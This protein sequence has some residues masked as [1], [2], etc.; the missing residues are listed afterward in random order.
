L[1]QLLATPQGQQ[2]QA[3]PVPVPGQV[4][5][6]AISATQEGQEA[7]PNP[8]LVTLDLSN[9]VDITKIPAVTQMQSAFQ[10]QVNEAREAAEAVQL[11]LLQMEQAQA[12]A[13]VK[14]PEQELADLTATFSQK[15]NALPEAQRTAQVRATME[16]EYYREEAA[17]QRRANQA[18]TERYEIEQDVGAWDRFYAPLRNT[19]LVEALNRIEQQALMDAKGNRASRTFLERRQD[20][21]VEKLAMPA[22]MMLLQQAGGGAPSPAAPAAPAAPAVPAAPPVVLPNQ[23]GAPAVSPMSALLNND[24]AALR[25]M[26]LLRD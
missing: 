15:W 23:G 14:T 6:E 21:V 4:A 20:L 22:I 5:P 25:Q 16:A 8:N 11:K 18:N 3:Q 2:P 19:P 24:L 17:I 9:P 13:G 10:K 1:A 7:A 12:Q 26:G